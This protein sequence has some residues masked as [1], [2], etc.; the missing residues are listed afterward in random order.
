VE[1][2]KKI[3][4]KNSVRG[5]V[6]AKWQAAGEPDWDIHQ[7]LRICKDVDG[8]LEAAGFEPAPKFRK[9]VKKDDNKYLRTWTFGCHFEW[10]NPRP[11]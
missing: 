1:V 3:K 9:A 4:R 11:K 8:K 2:L 7:T 5:M 6:V 10:L